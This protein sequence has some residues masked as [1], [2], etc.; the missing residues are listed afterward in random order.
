MYFEKCLLY[1]N[2]ECINLSQHRRNLIRNPTLDKALTYYDK[3]TQIPISCIKI[4]KQPLFQWEKS[5]T[6][7]LYETINVENMIADFYADKASTQTPKEARKSYINAMR[8]NVK[9]LNTLKK[10]AWKDT[11]IIQLKI[12]Q[13][14]YHYSKL[15]KSA[16]MQYRA[17]YDF[18]PNLIA[19]RR[20]YHLMNYSCHLWKDENDNSLLPLVKLEMAKSLPDDQMG[21]KLALIKDHKAQAVCSE[22]WDTWYQQNEAVYFKA[23]QTDMKIKPFT[24]KEAFQDLSKLI[25]SSSTDEKD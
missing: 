20:A 15:L 3:L 2:K 7:F 4:K 6:C 14:Y 17:M 13:E 8:F 21:E 18:K 11:Q 9:C 5:S 10:Y 23:I 24:L 12:M 1:N 16:S 25:S 19:I 22:Y